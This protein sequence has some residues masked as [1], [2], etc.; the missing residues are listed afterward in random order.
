MIVLLKEN[1][2]AS[3]LENLMNWLKSFDIEVHVS[4]GIHQ[5]ILGL[6]GD[7]SLLDIDLL[8]ALDIVEDV[9]RIQEPYK[10][11]NRKFHP[12]DTIVDVHGVKIGGGNFQI[13]AG[14]CSWIFPSFTCLK[15]STSFRSV[16]ETCKISSC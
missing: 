12:Q 16:P 13:I 4:K 10:N 8:K 11:A 3:Q 6:I 7:T 15:T 1:P 14:P 9:K 5:T 2:N